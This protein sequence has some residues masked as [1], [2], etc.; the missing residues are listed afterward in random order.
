MITPTIL[1]TLQNWWFSPVK[2]EESVKLQSS[3]TKY[4]SEDSK[5]ITAS[6][7][8]VY[9]RGIYIDKSEDNEFWKIRKKPSTTNDL[10]I[11]SNFQVG[12]APTVT[13]FHYFKEKQKI[14]EVIGNFFNTLVC[15]YSDF[16]D[17]HLTLQI[18][19]FD[20]DS[21]SSIREI[22]SGITKL[23]GNAAVTFPVVSPYATAVGVTSSLLGLIDNI[24]KHDLI[25]ESNLRLEVTEENTGSQLLQAGHWVFFDKPQKEGIEL[26]SNLQIKGEFHKSSYAIY[27]IK[28]EEAQEPQW[29]L[30]QK[31]ATLLSE[32]NNKG[33]SGRSAIE[34]LRETMDGYVRYKKVKR[35]QE[36]K[37]KKNLFEKTADRKQFS[38]DEEKQLERIESDES[39]KEFIG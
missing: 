20:V 10:L 22:F 37:E 27:S 21:Y 31:I 29:E 14:G 26:D 23:A 4:I 17:S 36:L 32:L 2:I 24:D 5:I 7:F 35:Y 39:I 25:M 19:A 28:K 33:N 11:L 15:S 9:L 13:R 12:T 30:S 8:S 3:A 1:L 6:P 38:I 16:K 18:Q 34:F